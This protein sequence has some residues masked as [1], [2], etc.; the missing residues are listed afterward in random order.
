MS[1]ILQ[2]NKFESRKQNGSNDLL[3]NQSII[4]EFALFDRKIGTELSL[5]HVSFLGA[6]DH[7]LFVCSVNQNAQLYNVAL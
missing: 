5:G 3:D 7:W 6:P 4:L 1:D 2:Q